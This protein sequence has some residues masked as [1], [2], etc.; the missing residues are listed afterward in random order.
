[1]V[2]WLAAR[3]AVALAGYLPTLAVTV[4]DV[5][6]LPAVMAVLL[7]PLIARRQ[8]RNVLRARGEE[9]G[10]RSLALL[11]FIAIGAV[12]AMIVVD[13]VA[14]LSLAGGAIF[15]LAACAVA[16]RLSGWRGLRTRTELLLWILHLGYLTLAAGLP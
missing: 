9:A 1:M 2:L 10:M 4:I 3:A 5:A 13:A 12:I 15:V 14:P 16:A 7:P 6:F 8:W 11:N